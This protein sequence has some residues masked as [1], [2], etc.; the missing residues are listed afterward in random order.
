VR[1]VDAASLILVDRSGGEPKILMGRRHEGHAFMPGRVVFPG[2][3]VDRS[4]HAMP[5]FGVLADHTQSRLLARTPR[6]TPSHMRALALCAIRETAEETG[7]LVGEKGLGQ[8]PDRGGGWTSFS[9]LA[10]FPALDA[11]HFVARAV[12]PPSLARRF[13]TR[14]FAADARAIAGR[15]EGVVGPDSELVAVKWLGLG[16]LETE[17]LA[18]ITRVVIAELAIRLDKGLE[19]DLPVPYFLER[20]GHWLREEV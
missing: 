7:L 1:P 14:F 12:T 2:G 10:I 16:E 13:D 8:P 17:N 15:M 3:R 4:D 11:L 6:A 5:A 19:R 18:A 9:T 20:R